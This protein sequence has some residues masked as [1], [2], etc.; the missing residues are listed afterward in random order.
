MVSNLIDSKMVAGQ[1]FAARLAR[2]PAVAFL[3]A[4]SSFYTVNYTRNWWNDLTGRLGWTVNAFDGSDL[5]VNGKKQPPWWRR[6]PWK[7]AQEQPALPVDVM[8]EELKKYQFSNDMQTGSVARFDTNQY[9]ANDPIEDRHIECH[10][11]SS[12]AIMFAVFDGHSGYHCSETLRKR[13]PQYLSPALAKASNNTESISDNLSNYTII[14]TEHL[15]NPDLEMPVS[16]AKKQAKLRT[17]SA[18]FSNHLLNLKTKFTYSDAMREAFNLLDKDICNEAIPDGVGD[19][20]LM[21]GLAGSCAIVSVVQ[22]DNLYIA[23][24]GIFY[25]KIT[26]LDCR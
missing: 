20:T 3:A 4:A 17:G 18:A 10:F 13:M 9:S 11:P 15:D 14:G 25:F 23:N 6:L 16:L 8:N 5:I 12:N 21:V 7:R 26:N 1:R 24:T 2:W 19:N 22:G